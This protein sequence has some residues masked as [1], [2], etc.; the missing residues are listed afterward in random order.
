MINIGIVGKK[1]KKTAKFYVLHMFGWFKRINSQN[2][3][4]HGV[5][6]TTTTTTHVICV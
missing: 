6:H 1:K 2:S 5:C 3:T 4:R